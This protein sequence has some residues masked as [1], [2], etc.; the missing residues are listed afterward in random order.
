MNTEIIIIVFYKSDRKIGR[1]PGNLSNISGLPKNLQLSLKPA[2]I[3]V[4]E[5]RN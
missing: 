1:I 3:R 2:S 5:T 4:P